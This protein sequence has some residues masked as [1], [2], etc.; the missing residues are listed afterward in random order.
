VLETPLSEQK[1]I[2]YLLGELSEE[3]QVEIEDRAFA[4]EKVL[5]EILAVEQD[6]LDDYVSG[7]IPAEKRRSFETHFLASEERRKKV[8]FA[9]ALA[10]VVNAT[11]APQEERAV[12]NVAPDSSWR[13]ALTAFFAR[14]MTAYSFA[15]ASLLLFAVGSWLVVDRVRLRSELAQLRSNQDSQLAQRQ[16]LERDLANERLKN[17]ELLASRGTPSPEA[18]TPETVPT[19]P[20]KPATPG[21]PIIATLVFLPGMSRGGGTS[22]PEVSIAKDVSLLRLQVGIDP[23]E[24]YERYRAE[25]RNAKGQQV[26]AQANLVARAG[27]HGRNISL[28]IPVKVLSDGRYEVTLKGVTEGGE[29][30]A[31]GF[32]YFDVVKK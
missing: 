7:D 21:S 3:E 25:V 31:V 32:Y 10:T 22:V 9:K 17:E 27:H 11:P 19:S 8:A 6:L 18:P 5:Q 15:L 12:V 4:D 1:I 29:S 16:Q 14:P 13:T 30:E 20:T 26:L 23:Q 2:S 28:R 24:G